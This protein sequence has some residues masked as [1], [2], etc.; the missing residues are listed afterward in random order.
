MA[1]VGLHD[2]GRSMG[3]DMDYTVAGGKDRHLRTAFFHRSG[4]DV[5]GIKGILHP[6]VVMGS[7]SKQ[8]AETDSLGPGADHTFRCTNQNL[9]FTRFAE[10][11]IL[12]F[13]L[14]ETGKYKT[15]FLSAGC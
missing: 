3:V 8:P 12:Q 5:A 15:F 6:G 13:G 7:G 9:S 2:R 11:K 4:H 10:F 1:N 14:F